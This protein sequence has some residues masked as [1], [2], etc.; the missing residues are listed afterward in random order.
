MLIKN[1]VDFLVTVNNKP[2]FAI[3][4]KLSETIASSN[5]KYCKEKLNIPFVYQVLTIVA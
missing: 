2:W 5:T 3:E 1:E 4:V